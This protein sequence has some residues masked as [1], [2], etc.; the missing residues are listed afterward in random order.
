MLRDDMIRQIRLVHEWDVI[1]IGGGATGLWC[2]LDAASRG[3]R[4]ILLERNDFASVTSGKSTKLFHGGLRYLRQGHIGL[5]REALLERGRLA[6]N[7]PH[8]FISRP[9]LV[10]YYSLGEKLL[11]HIGMTLY[12]L[13]AGKLGLQKHQPLSRE[14]CMEKCPNLFPENLKGGCLFYDGQFDDARFA[15]DLVKTIHDHGGVVLNYAEVHAFT[16]Q[17]GKISGVGVIDHNNGEFFEL[18]GKVILNAS[19]IF[20]DEL[21]KMDNPLSAPIMSFSRGSHIVLDRNFLPGNTALIVPKTKDKRLIFLIPWLN[22]LLIGTTDIPV[23]KVSDEDSVAT[24]EEID[25]L[26]ETAGAYLQKKPKRED[27]L[28]VFAGIRPLVKR[29]SGKATSKL[30]RT[31]KIFLSESGLLTIAGGK[32]TTARQMA[33]D[34][35]DKAIKHAHLEKKA[36]RTKTLPIHETKKHHA[37]SPLHPDLPYTKEDI[38]RAVKDELALTLIDV[39]ARRTRSL[40]LNAEAAIEI[41]PQVAALMATHLGQDSAW[42]EKQLKAFRT[43]AKNYLPPHKTAHNSQRKSREK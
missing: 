30:S 19:G 42:I 41:A 8:L 25:F 2:A 16:K 39:L 38:T 6:K 10:P 24:P 33:E 26:L 14:K 17:S 34:A 36:C 13:L 37:P 31:H 35:I 18:R 27:I 3:F 11:Y 32:W 9:F 40:L 22:K 21:R 4:T 7:A 12:D 29:K 20:V 43:F 15:I 1:V 28:S 5:V 23:E